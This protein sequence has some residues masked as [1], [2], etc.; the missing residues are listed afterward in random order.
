MVSVIRRL[1]IVPPVV[2][3]AALVYFAAVNREPPVRDL[4][5]EAATVARFVVAEPQTFVPRVTG[6]GTVEPARTWDAIAQVAGRVTYVNPAFVR[7]GFLTKDDVIIRLAPED[8]EL[9]IA[10]T[11]ADIGSAAA[12]IEEL[13][14]TRETTELSLQIE[15]NALTLDEAELTRQETLLARGVATETAVEQQKSAVLQQQSS[16]QN[17]ENQ[18]ALIPAQRRALEQSK[19]KAEVSLEIAKLNLDRTTIKAPFDARVAEADVEIDQY[20]AVGSTMGAL[21]GL[22]A[23]E[24][25]VQIPPAL[26]AGFARF[27][28]AVTPEQLRD[29]GAIRDRFRRLDILGASVRVGFAGRGFVWPASVTRISDTVDPDTRSIGM[30]ITVDDPYGTRQPG[31]RP[32][33]VKG[34]FAEVELRAPPVEGVILIPR[35]AIS[36]GRVKVAGDD[37]RLRFQDV[38][39]AF[40][41]G[42][43]AALE[44]GLEPG[45]RVIVSD[46][47]PSIAGMLLRPVPDDGVAERLSEVAL[48]GHAA[49]AANP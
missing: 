24:I 37:N 21:D 18:L 46:L 40:E 34:M 13:D 29:P 10:E 4:P 22:D 9:E 2:A 19:A 32:P 12:D 28:F 25:D 14:L 5:E 26:M 27:A 6:F 31:R 7:G 38:A 48:K 20:V 47:S 45:T 43:I 11:R 49:G 39:V 30:I 3:G 15:R 41:M 44:G 42:D 17:L 1:L 8:Y 16:V 33:L 35:N 23:A 36:N